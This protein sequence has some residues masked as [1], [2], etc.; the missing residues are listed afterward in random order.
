MNSIKMTNSETQTVF[1]REVNI[2]ARKISGEMVLVP[3]K[4]NVGDLASIYNLNEV[5]CLVWELIDGKVTAG[6]IIE[7]IVDE[8]EVEPLVAEKD[9]IE[10]LKQLEQVAAISRDGFN[11]DLDKG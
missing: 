6:Q 9:V 3:I 11:N 1:T 2:V 10:F 4:H 8:Y 5:G 7:A